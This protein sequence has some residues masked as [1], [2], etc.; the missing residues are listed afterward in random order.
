MRISWYLGFGWVSIV[1]VVSSGVGINLLN[2]WQHWLFYI[3]F[4][5]T[6]VYMSVRFRL[7]TTQLW[8]RVHYR[9]MI[10]YGKI[11]VKEYDAA[12]KENREFNIEIPCRELAEL[13]FGQ[14]QAQRMNLLGTDVRTKYYNGLVESYPQV[15]LEGIK[16]E[17]HKNV[18][19][20]VYRDINACELGPDIVIA[21][22]IELKHNQF[23]VAR[24]LHA[25]LL[26]RVR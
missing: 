24:Y 15:F 13:M 17:R 4:L 20:G 18:L 1:T 5:I 14:D 2:G 12:K 19:S 9:A 26:G 7:F 6:A 11:A 22:E 3:P 21:K 10:P 25:M 16:P 8:R 23:E